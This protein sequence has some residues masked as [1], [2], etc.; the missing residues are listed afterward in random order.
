MW[1]RRA[2]LMAAGAAGLGALGIGLGQPG[3]G[4]LGLLIAAYLIGTWALALNP[5]RLG[6]GV[7]GGVQFSA[8]QRRTRPGQGP[9]AL[10]P[11]ER[12]VLARAALSGRALQPLDSA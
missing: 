2:V 8:L 3:F 12:P 7:R 4:I 9:H 1:S 11:F 6:T 10:S 5:G